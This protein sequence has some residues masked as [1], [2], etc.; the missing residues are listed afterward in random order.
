MSTEAE[1]RI[2]VEQVLADQRMEGLY[3]TQFCL[4]LLES[5]IEGKLS[6]EIL[7][8]K[9]NEHYKDKDVKPKVA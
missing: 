9:L 5:Y 7:I 3:P 1:R 4:D 6:S 2:L 8:Q